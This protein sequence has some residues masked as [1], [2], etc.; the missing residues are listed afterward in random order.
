MTGQNP[1][2]ARLQDSFVEVMGGVCTPV[3]VVTT[4]NGGRPHGTTV[5]AFSSLSRRPPMIIVALDETS[6]LLRIVRDTGILGVNVLTDRQSG[7]ATRFA[8]KGADK[9]DGIDWDECDRLPRLA[10]ASGWLACE[11][12]DLVPGGDH[13]IVLGRVLSADGGPGNPLVYHRRTFG[14]HQPLRL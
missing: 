11:A 12:T 4:L 13:T 3:A 6:E 2:D 10:A 8:G 14:T 1:P 7:L 5:S 9:F